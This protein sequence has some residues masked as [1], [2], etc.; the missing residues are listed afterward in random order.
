VDVSLFSDDPSLCQVD[1]TKQDICEPG[2]SL[3]KEREEIGRKEVREEGGGRGIGRRE[4]GGGRREEGGG[5]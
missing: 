3:F 2:M 4:E 1:K 5:R